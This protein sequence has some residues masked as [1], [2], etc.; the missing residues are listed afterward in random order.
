MSEPTVAELLATVQALAARID[1][2]ETELATV[3]ADLPPREVPED[4]VLAIAAAVSA[5]LGHRARLTQVH[6][7]TGQAWTEQGRA[8]V[9]RRDV[10]HGVR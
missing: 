1:S 2:L 5:F 7:R 8:A 9:Q 4:V 10:M 6:Y 3:R